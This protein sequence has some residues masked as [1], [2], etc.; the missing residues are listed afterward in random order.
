MPYCRIQTAMGAVALVGT[1]LAPSAV[2]R[3]PQGRGP[4][5]LILQGPG[6]DIRASVSILP[7]NRRPEGQAGIVIEQVV[8]AGPADTA[9]LRRGDIVTQF[10]GIAIT[11][12][13]QFGKVVRD[14]PP[15]RPVKV[16]MWR[17]GV[18]REV[19][20]APVAGRLE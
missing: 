1:L 3:V 20:V 19:F 10:D 17:D 9:G 7:E 2:A 8:R 11:D 12:P 14:T 4:D 16:T 6:S 13:V 18:R 15:G 5:S